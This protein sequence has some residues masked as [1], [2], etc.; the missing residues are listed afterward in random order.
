ME[1]IMRRSK[2]TKKTTWTSQMTT[3]TSNYL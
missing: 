1:K 2:S 3:G